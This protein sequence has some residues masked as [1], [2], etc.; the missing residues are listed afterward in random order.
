MFPVSLPVEECI[1]AAAPR[2]LHAPAVV[3]SMGLIA[4]KTICTADLLV[5][6]LVGKESTNE[7]FRQS[8]SNGEFL[9]KTSPYQYTVTTYPDA[10]EKKEEEEEESEEDFGMDLFG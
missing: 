9:L 10:E 2:Q 4:A 8:K 7:S 5:D 3:H 6:W 1:D